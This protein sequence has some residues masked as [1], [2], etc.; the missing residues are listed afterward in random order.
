MTS[1]NVSLPDD[2][3]ALKALLLAREAALRERDS[4]LE[5]LRDT[6]ATLQK[7]LSRTERWKSRA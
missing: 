5:D 6:V 2:I 7:T 4:D 3:D 1:S